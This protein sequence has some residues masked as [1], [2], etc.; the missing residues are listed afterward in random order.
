MPSPNQYNEVEAKV[1]NKKA[2]SYSLYK[3]HRMTNFAE[4]VATGAKNTIGP[5]SFDPHAMKEK[6]IGVYGDK[7]ERVTVSDSIIM[8]ANNVPAMNKYKMPKLDV[9]Y[10]RTKNTIMKPETEK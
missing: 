8:E 9:T 5:G 3:S 2:P 7:G 1:I 10:E 6:I 4:I